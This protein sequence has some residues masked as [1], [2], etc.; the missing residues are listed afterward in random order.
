M[1]VVGTGAP[2]TLHVRLKHCE[3]GIWRDELRRRHSAAL[4]TG[5]DAVQAEMSVLARLVDQARKPAPADQPYDVAG[6]SRVLAPLIRA[7]AAAAL[8]RYVAAVRAFGTEADTTA[9]QVRA[10]LDSATAWTATL[11]ALHFVETDAG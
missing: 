10:A 2:S 5:T 3:L 7:A 11:L 9:D 6:P 1:K 8:E 4:R